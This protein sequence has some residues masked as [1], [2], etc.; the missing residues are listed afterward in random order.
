M[1]NVESIIDWKTG[2]FNF[3][4]MPLDR[5]TVKLARWYG[6][7]FMFEDETVKEFRFSGAVTKYRT[8]D[9]VLGMIAK[10]TKVAFQEKDGKILVRKIE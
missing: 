9:Y 10:T 6:V 8:L 2:R 7:Q 1:E 3:E 5:L 4:D